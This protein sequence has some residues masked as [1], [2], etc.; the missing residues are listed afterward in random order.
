MSIGNVAGAENATGTPKHSGKEGIELNQH[1][2]GLLPAMATGSL[3]GLPYMTGVVTRQ[4]S[5][6]NPTGAKGGGCLRDPDPPTLDLPHSGAALDLGRGWKVRPFVNLRAH[7]TKVLADITG[8]GVISYVWLASDVAGYNSL[9][10]RWYWDNEPEPS[11][12]AP[13]G[14]FFAIGHDEAPH[15]V[16]S[17]P[18]VVGPSRGCASYWPMPFRRHARLTLENSSDEDVKVIAYKVRVPVTRRRRRRSLLPYSV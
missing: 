16:L 11:V 6:E 13:A 17:I 5:A 3:A 18:I 8:P 1:D 10:F 12:E 7:E 2:A 4:I 15:E 14:Q 9:I